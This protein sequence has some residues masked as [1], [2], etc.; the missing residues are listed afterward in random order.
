MSASPVPPPSPQSVSAVSGSSNLIALRGRRLHLAGSYEVEGLW[1]GAYVDDQDV[2]RLRAQ[3]G[4]AA[5]P[6][7]SD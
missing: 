3:A 1:V 4:Q 6:P 5:P 7:P 2:Q